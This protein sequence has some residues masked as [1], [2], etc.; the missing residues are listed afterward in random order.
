MDQLVVKHGDKLF[1]VVRSDLDP[2]PQA[3]QGMHAMRQF[4]SEFPKVEQ[5]WFEASNHIAFLKVDNE[6]ALLKMIDRL[7]RKGMRVSMFREPDLDDSLTAFAT[8]SASREFL[9][10]LKLALS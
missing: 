7:T 6:V 5:D 2:G 8:D 3:V 1:V 10:H 9:L 4:I